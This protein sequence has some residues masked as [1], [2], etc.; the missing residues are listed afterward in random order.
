MPYY[1]SPG[2]RCLL[3]AIK[4]ANMNTTSDQE[5][6]VPF[7]KYVIRNIVATNPSTSL[8][9]AVGGVYTEAAKS[10]ITVVLAIQVFSGL[11]GGTKFIDLT[12]ASGVTGDTITASTLYLSLTTAQGSA[13]TMDLYVYGDALP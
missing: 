5:I 12:L 10:G 6:P 9:L 13:A 1:T 11:T 8:T 3:G 7:G 2:H 4:G